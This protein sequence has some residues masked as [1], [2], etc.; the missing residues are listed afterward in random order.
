[1]PRA[2]RPSWRARRSSR[3]GARARTISFR[4]ILVRSQ[5]RRVAARPRRHLPPAPPRPERRRHKEDAGPPKSGLPPR[6]HRG[7]DARRHPSA[8]APRPARGAGG[9]RDSTR[10][11]GTGLAQPGL[12]FL[13]RHG[14]PRLHHPG[15]DPAGH[16]RQPRVVHPIHTLPG[17]D[18]PGPPGGAADV[19]DH[20]GRPHR[21]PPG[22]RV[23]AR[24]GHGRGRGHDHVPE[25][26]PGE[27]P[28]LP[29]SRGLSPPDH[30]RG[31]HPRPT[32][33]H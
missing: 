29:R 22:Q 3:R 20:G 28:G 7:D 6:P 10:P 30:R 17:G 21:P 14:L 26:G 27:G 4:R 8:P 5:W 16:P 12:P 13:S 15:G 1:M 23:P 31:P 18:R 33:R 32:P 25:P 24:R 19:P 2:T 11:P 9:A